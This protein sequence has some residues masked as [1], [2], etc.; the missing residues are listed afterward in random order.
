V[1]GHY[2]PQLNMGMVI[3]Y[4]KTEVFQK[5]HWLKINIIIVTSISLLIVLLIVTWLARSLWEAHMKSELLLK[6]ILPV[7]VIEELK[8]KKHFVARNVHKVSIVFMDIV[9]F[10]AFTASHSPVIVVTILDEL[11]SIL[12]SLCD[13]YQ[14]E[15]IKTI[16]DAHMSVAGLIFPQADH[17]ARAVNMA[18][19]AI[20]AIQN[21]NLDNHTNFAIRIGI[22]SGSI[23]AG[24]IGKRKFSYDVWGNA[25]NRAS[26]M[27]STGTPNIVQITTDTYEALPHKENY[28]ISSQQHIVVKGL[29]EVDTYLVEG[30]TGSR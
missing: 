29:G 23:T 25:V 19:D 4:D 10:T 17:A 22:D 26:R 6:N 7:F 9:G 27:E 16:G 1:I 30:R 28:K 11:F 21:Y 24:I 2:V 8:E 3:Q 18:L 12:D 13:K 14:L 20:D 15:K 5:L